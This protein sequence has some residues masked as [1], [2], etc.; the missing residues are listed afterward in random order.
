MTEK[1]TEKKYTLRQAITKALEQSI[2]Y[3]SAGFCKRCDDLHL[4]A[5]HLRSCN[6][7]AEEIYLW[8]GYGKE[9]HDLRFFG[10]LVRA[11]EDAPVSGTAATDVPRL[12]ARIFS[13]V[14]SA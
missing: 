3:E 8:L 2:R 4:E 10:R 1:K 9:K 5:R 7:I 14:L 13:L 12:A 6:L 11:L